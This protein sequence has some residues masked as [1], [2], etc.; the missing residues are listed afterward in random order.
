[1]PCTRLPSVPTVLGFQPWPGHA[2]VSSSDYSGDGLHLDTRV[3]IERLDPLELIV[4]RESGFAET[5]VH[6][7]GLSLVRGAAYRVRMQ[8]RNAA[9]WTA[10][11]RPYY[12]TVPTE[13]TLPGAQVPIEPVPVTAVPL[14]IEPSYVADVTDVLPARSWSMV[15]GEWVA[16]P[17][18][19]RGRR[20]TTMVWRNLAASQRDTV[21]DFLAARADVPEAY[22]TD[23]PAHGQRSW[24][25]RGGTIITTQTGPRSWT[26]EVT[27][28]E[29]FAQRFWTVGES[30]VGGPDRIR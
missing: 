2:Q 20:G 24:H 11:S 16:R 1:M 21:R 12:A 22:Q 30:V 14:P 6:V 28:D 13:L 26:V 4:D 23:D 29:V 9:G 17:A 8:H 10:W 25:V 19:T 18:E 27:A 15:T 7:T 3:A 5:N